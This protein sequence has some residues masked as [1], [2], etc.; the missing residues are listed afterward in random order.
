MTA[1]RGGHGT[2]AVVVVIGLVAD[3]IVGLAVG[4]D[5]AGRTGG[6]LAVAWVVTGPAG[7][8]VCAAVV[9]VVMVEVGAPV[10]VPTVAALP[11]V[12]TALSPKEPGEAWAT[13]PVTIIPA[14]SSN[15]SAGATIIGLV[16]DLTSACRSTSMVVSFAFDP[17]EAEPQDWRSYIY[18]RYGASA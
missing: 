9:V 5:T 13:T 15:A 14:A 1:T 8:M 11:I 6:G 7:E 17:L 3:G 2:T 12:R 4:A 16:R 10:S 18:R